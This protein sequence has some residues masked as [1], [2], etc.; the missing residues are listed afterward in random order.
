MPL[1]ILILGVALRLKHY[2]ENRSLWLDEAWLGTSINSRDYSEI[3]KRVEI[4][5]G[6][7]EPPI[8]F[9]LIEKFFVNTL[10]NNEMVLRLFPLI[11]GILALGGFYL[12]AKRFLEGRLLLLALALF[13]VGEPLVYYA[14]ELKQY[15]TD[16]L[17]TIAL[18][19]L[20]DRYLDKVMGWLD[21]LLWGVLGALLLWVSNA[22][23]FIL[24]AIACAFS[25]NA[26]LNRRLFKNYFPT[27]LMYALWM[28]SFIALYCLSLS[29]MVGNHE[30]MKNWRG[31]LLGGDASF[32]QALQFLGNI[33]TESFKNP[34]A[35][36]WPV[37][38][39]FLFGLGAWRL[40]K[41]NAARALLLLLPVFL[42]FLAAVLGKYP[43]RGRLILFL[44]PI[45][46]IVIILGLDASKE[47]IKSQYEK[48]VLIALSVV[49]LAFPLKEMAYYLIHSRTQVENRDVL[50][51]FNRL[52]KPGDFIYLNTSGQFAFLYYASS[53]GYG[54]LFPQYLIGQVNGELQYG[55]TIGKFARFV[56]EQD[57]ASYIY[58][59]KE[60]DSFKDGVFKVYYT[61]DKDEPNMVF[62]DKFYDYPETHRTWVFLSRAPEEDD[63]QINK[64]I[65]D[66][67]EKRGKRIMGYERKGA[68]IYLYEMNKKVPLL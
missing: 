29:Q 39:V 38:G 31:S 41:T 1:F 18:L 49:L 21:C 12:L 64:W 15:S 19:L 42:V 26:Y 54:K 9:N 58:Y 33:V 25:W 48:V 11:C 62:K 53:L 61:S 63:V 23:I 30:L 55:M 59:Q 51:V 47:F 67:F 28:A 10:G 17:V 34:G 52:Y 13:A 44:V 3:L 27:T 32:L 6:F 46:Y 4:F 56:G 50:E 22:S 36:G 57:G 45:Y 66:S 8:I 14:A 37:L 24:P 60:Y 2:F 5:P 40:I 7:P 20:A 35:L 65:V 68:A 16:L 43:S